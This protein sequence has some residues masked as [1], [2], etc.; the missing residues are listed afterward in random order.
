MTSLSL[1]AKGTVGLIT[2]S[3]GRE[4]PLM[5]PSLEGDYDHSEYDDD[6]YDVV[7]DYLKGG[8]ADGHLYT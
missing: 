6:D 7:V 4:L 2:L 5:D 1:R 3:C 8:S